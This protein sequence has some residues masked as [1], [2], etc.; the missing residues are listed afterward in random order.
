M[1]NIE[2]TR[3]VW[4]DMRHFSTGGTYIN[5]LTEEDTGERIQAAYGKNFQ[6]LVDL[7]TKWDPTNL[8]R[9]NKNIAPVR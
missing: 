8:F 9:T 6:R 2:W 4:R 7:K 3:G 1:A 5:F